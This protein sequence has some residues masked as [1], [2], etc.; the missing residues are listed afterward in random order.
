MNTYR[1]HA[2]NPSNGKI[3]VTQ[4]EDESSKKASAKVMAT[5]L[6]IYNLLKVEI[7]NEYKNW[8]PVLQVA[9][10]PAVGRMETGP[11]KIN[12]DWCGYFLRGDNAL[13]ASHDGVEIEEWFNKLPE[14]HRKG[15]WIEMSNVI[16]FLKEMS[17]CRNK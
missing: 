10:T 13:G 16:S 2:Y 9:I 8:E 1:V 17:A 5:Y 15:I 14:E 7:L 6:P 4:V 3:S 12:D 11:L